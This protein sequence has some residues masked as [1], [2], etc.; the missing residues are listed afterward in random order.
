MKLLKTIAQKPAF[1]SLLGT[2]STAVLG[3]VTIA[4][5]A[6]GMVTAAFGDW[7]LFL[8]GYTLLEML[9]AG[10]LQTALIRHMSGGDFHEKKRWIGS[11]ALIGIGIGLMISLLN[12]LVYQLWPINELSQGFVYL[13]WWS[14]PALL[15]SFPLQLSQWVLQESGRFRLFYMLKLVSQLAFLISL[16]VFSGGE[17]QLR[18]VAFLFFLSQ[19]FGGL[20]AAF[21]KTL[22]LKVLIHAGKQEMRALLSFGR[23]S[24]GTLISAN[25]LRG[26]DTLLIGTFLGPQAVALYSLPQKLFEVLEIPLRAVMTIALPS[27]AGKLQKGNHEGMQQEF[28]YWTGLLSIL[29]VPVAI[30][31]FLLADYL[32]LM[33]GGPGYE[34]SAWILRAFILFTFLLPLDR[35]SGVALDVLKK[36]QLNFLKVVLMLLVNVVGDV[37]VLSMTASPLGV[38]L[39][40]VVTYGSGAWLGYFFLKAYLP[41]KMGDIFQSGFKS[42]REAHLYVSINLGRR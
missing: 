23:Y 15:L 12:W 13:F 28:N 22:G 9:R 34:A 8:T 6:R 10:L 24:T 33:L 40:S 4:L 14:G 36:P 18:E 42:I 5:L 1:V 29:M 19:A 17:W 3:F 35:F 31:L 41:L 30:I 39:V 2:G 27:M 38:A 11:A 21:T 37:L 20:L 7:M 25:L 32:V 16:F 26:S